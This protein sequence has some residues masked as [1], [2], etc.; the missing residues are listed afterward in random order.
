M[1]ERIFFDNNKKSSQN[2]REAL[3]RRRDT[4]SGAQT[5]LVVILRRIFR[6]NLRQQWKFLIIALSSM[7]LVAITTAAM[8][9]LLQQAADGIFVGKNESLL[10][11]LPVIVIGLTLVRGVADYFS[12]VSLAYLGERLVADT[13][14]RMF[15]CLVFADLAWLQRIHSGR[16]IAAFLQDAGMIRATAAQTLNAVGQNALKTVFL[17]AMMVYFDWRMAMLMMIGLPFAVYLMG[18]QSR[19]VHRSSVL[20]MEETGDL[21]SLISQTLHGVRIIKAYGQEAH[22]TRR[23][24]EVI[25]RTFAY[26]MQAVR[27]QVISGPLTETLTGIGVAAAIF[28]A[29]YQGISGAMTLGDFIGFVTSVM[30]LYQ[31]LKALATLRTGLQQGIAAASRVYDIID[32]ESEIKD[33]PDAKPLQ[34]SVGA[35]NF[36]RVTFAYG[37]EE[38]VVVDFSLVVP[39]GKRVA[40]VGPSGAGKTTILNLVLRFFDPQSGTI[41]ID[42]QDINQASVASVRAA[43]S[44]VTQDPVIFDDTVNANIA[45]GSAD[46]NDGKIVEAAKAAAAHGF[47]SNLPQGYETVLGEAGN[48]LSGGERQRIA[49]ARAMT[50][51]TPIVLLDEPTSALDAQSEAKVQTAMTRLF[52]NRTVLMIAHRLATVREADIICVMDKGRLVETGT[53]TQLIAAGGLYAQLYRSQVGEFLADVG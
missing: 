30:L 22:E 43:S 50:R 7:I 49:F 17:V 42:G 4:F 48:R 18:R 44:L 28:Y 45:Y 40:L 34:V 29:G 46:I 24:R 38:P 9:L 31:P 37:K 39:P 21:S 5:S 25:E 47:I 1:A 11:L 35:I 53:H 41:S 20:T 33:R 14:K 16:F 32:H 13:R 2:T 26:S 15:D 8:P 36:D 10:Y 19:K 27:A 12:R 6:E 51:N 3:A 23:V 52:A